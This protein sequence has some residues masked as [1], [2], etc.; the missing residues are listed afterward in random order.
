MGCWF[1]SNSIV[2]SNRCVVDMKLH[3]LQAGTNN[4]I[5]IVYNG[6]GLENTPAL[7]SAYKKVLCHA[8]GPTIMIAKPKPKEIRKYKKNKK[9]KCRAGALNAQNEDK[10]E[11]IGWENADGDDLGSGPTL[12]L[13]PA[14]ITLTN[15]NT[16]RLYA[17]VRFDNQGEPLR[18]S[19]EIEVEPE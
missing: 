3:R 11:H 9:I 15:E 7:D 4:E 14:E 19:V 17:R 5:P 13:D 1:K 6:G 16:Y 18:T 2:K 12:E 8:D 10:S